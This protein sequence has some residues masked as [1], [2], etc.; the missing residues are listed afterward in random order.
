MQTEQLI[1]AFTATVQASLHSLRALESAL[2]DEQS[3]LLGKDPQRLEDIVGHKLALL[4]QLEPSVRARERL[5]ETVD[6]PPGDDG[7]DNIVEM[8]NQETLTNDWDELKSQAQRVVALNDHNG[9]LTLQSQRNAR[10]ALAILTGRP[11]AQDTYS[12][13]RRK[14]GSTKRFS[15]GR[16]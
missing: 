6:L 13:L 5:Q 2:Q 3:A 7:G 8:L 12:T 15:L 9:R 14:A 11:V 4:K 1:T 16:V 10:E